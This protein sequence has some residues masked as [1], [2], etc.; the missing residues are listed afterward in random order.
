M[1]IDSRK[2]DFTPS[3][4][5]GSSLTSNRAPAFEIDMIATFM[6]LFRIPSTSSLQKRESVGSGGVKGLRSVGVPLIGYALGLWLRAGYGDPI[7]DI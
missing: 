6:S 5:P 2:V 7:C 4:L 1:L 3:S